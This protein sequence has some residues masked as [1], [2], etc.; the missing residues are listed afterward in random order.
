MKLPTHVEIREVGPRDGFQNEPETIATADKIELINRLARTGLRRI[1]VASFVRPDVIPQLSDGV[2]VL[3][4]IHGKGGVP[5]DVSLMVLVPNSKGLD[6]ALKVRETFSEVAI[7]VS[8]SETHNKRNVNRTI[9]ESMADN[10]IIA[11]RI[12]AED[13][14][15]AAVIATSYGCPFEGKV[16]MNRVLDIA[17]QFAAAGATEVGFGDTT[18]MANPAY[19][20]EFFAAAIERLPGVE[21]TAHFHNTRGQ[22]LA[23]AYAALQVGCTSFES[24]FGEL[25]GC[26]VP[27]G[28]TG[29]IASEDLISMFEEMGVSTG[30]SL[31][32]MI[33]AARA[34]QSVLGRKLTSHSIVAGPIDWSP[35]PDTPSCR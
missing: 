12:V 7:F 10:A 9:A 13:L 16:P 32:A 5:D 6:N 20:G 8:A 29:N 34:A 11:K 3:R 17:E 27:A 22:G 15:C 19:V 21:V 30:V 14:R 23:N 26:P 1:E 35:H 2:E 25:G 31:P 33:D 18:G 24:S 28:S 4:G